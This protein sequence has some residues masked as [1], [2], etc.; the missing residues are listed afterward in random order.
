MAPN[1]IIM[2]T[3]CINIHTVHVYH[4]L[5]GAITAPSRSQTQD[6]DAAK[7]PVKY[8]T[9]FRGKQKKDTSS[10][11]NEEGASVVESTTETTSQSDDKK[12]TESIPEGA[13]G[14]ELCMYM[15]SVSASLKYMFVCMHVHR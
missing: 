1:A 11:T 7:R 9:R 6:G 15:S 3:H 8:G 10:H 12:E 4:L 14:K 13:T 2:I 5:L